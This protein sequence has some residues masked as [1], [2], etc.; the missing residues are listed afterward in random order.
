MSSQQLQIGPERDDPER[1]PEA[2]PAMSGPDPGP[3][4]HLVTEA[5]PFAFTDQ[6]FSEQLL[7]DLVDVMIR[8]NCH[9]QDAHNALTLAR[10]NVN[11][12]VTMI[13]EERARQA[14]AW[15]LASMQQETLR[16]VPKP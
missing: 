8:C 1:L 6:V 11:V 14:A 9:A 13:A 3:H 2:P 10:G 4:G 5:I 7:D 15:A 16:D 12:A